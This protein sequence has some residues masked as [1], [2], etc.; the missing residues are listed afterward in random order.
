MA[1][2]PTTAR[3]ED[4]VRQAS[5]DVY[6]HRLNLSRQREAQ[7]QLR[8]ADQALQQHRHNLQ[9]GNAHFTR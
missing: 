7:Q 9:S 8:E 6:A 5:A 1:H 4:A 2:N 3:L